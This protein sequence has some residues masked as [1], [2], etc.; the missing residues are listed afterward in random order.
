MLDEQVAPSTLRV[1][2]MRYHLPLVT[3]SRR[4]TRCG[5]VQ[6]G[7]ELAFF[8]AVHQSRLASDFAARSE[9][10]GGGARCARRGAL[11]DDRISSKMLGGAS[12]T[13]SKIRVKYNGT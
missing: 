8:F 1:A 9:E 10:R 7:D 5:D 2:T 4:G 11:G 12:Q 13:V 6:C 3:R